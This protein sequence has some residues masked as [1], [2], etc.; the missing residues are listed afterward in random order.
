MIY[1]SIIL[2]II[3][4][5]IV[6]KTGI[7]NH[8]LYGKTLLNGRIELTPLENYGI[9]G[10]LFKKNPEDLKK[11]LSVFLGIFST[12]Y[13]IMLIFRKSMSKMAKLSFALILGGGLSNLLDRYRFGYVKDYFVLK[14]SKLRFIKNLVFN[15]ADM[16]VF[17]GGILHLLR[18]FIRGR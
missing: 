11:I 2:A 16:F 7:E 1:I 4:L 14:T 10:G 6:I 3:V 8:S 17:A 13:V 9:S 5:E 15:L 12:V 18:K